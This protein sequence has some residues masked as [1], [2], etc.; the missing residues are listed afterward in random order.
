MIESQTSFIDH[1]SLGAFIYLINAG[2]ELEFSVN[3]IECF[4]S[5][6]KSSGFVSL[7]SENREQSFDSAEDL[8]VNALAGEDK[9]FAVWDK[10]EIKTLF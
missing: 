4:I 7:W 6:D 5:C 1:K 10:I 3:G 8:L 9:L 2:R